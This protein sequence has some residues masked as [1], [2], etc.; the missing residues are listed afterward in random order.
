MKF[1][2]VIVCYLHVLFALETLERR[3]IGSRVYFHL[4][5]AIKRS[6]RRRVLVCKTVAFSSTLCELDLTHNLLCLL[7]DV[8]VCAVIIHAHISRRIKQHRKQNPTCVFM[9]AT[10]KVSFG[11]TINCIPR[12]VPFFLSLALFSRFFLCLS[13]VLWVEVGRRQ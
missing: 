8:L 13:S 12:L 7:L 3:F 11:L 9:D 2:T 10:T 1:S 6:T 5:S 4:E